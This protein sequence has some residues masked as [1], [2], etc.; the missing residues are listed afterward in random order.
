M[1]GRRRA[2]IAAPPI[3]VVVIA[4]SL[5]LWW[6][7]TNQWMR[8]PAG[9]FCNLNIYDDT[10]KLVENWG[11][12]HLPGSSLREFGGAVL[13]SKCSHEEERS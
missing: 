13:L 1:R 8:P 5:T 12:A 2:R 3:P 9:G 4:S 10:K 7:S 6:N 11:L